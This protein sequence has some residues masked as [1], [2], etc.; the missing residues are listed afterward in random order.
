[1]IRRAG[2]DMGM[3]GDRRGWSLGSG[4]S[5]FQANLLLKTYG[6]TEAPVMVSFEHF[7]S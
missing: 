2:G 4:T 3:K 5:R 6:I 7:G 1:M